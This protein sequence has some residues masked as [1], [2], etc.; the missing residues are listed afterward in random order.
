MVT[1]V[2]CYYY[3]SYRTHL[4]NSKMPKNLLQCVDRHQVDAITNDFLVHQYLSE[5]EHTLSLLCKHKE[6]NRRL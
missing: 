4:R 5:R 6:K 3:N 2:Q 1:N